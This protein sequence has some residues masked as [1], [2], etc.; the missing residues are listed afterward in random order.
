[1]RILSTKTV[2]FSKDL[3]ELQTVEAS[4]GKKLYNVFVNGMY[5]KTYS[6]LSKDLKELFN[7]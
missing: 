1:M 2:T 4:F 3:Y 7:L 6:R 5:L